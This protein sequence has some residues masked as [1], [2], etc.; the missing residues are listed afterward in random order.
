MPST[1]TPFRVA[2]VPGVTPGKWTKAWS[3][4]SS[5]PIEVT[6]IEVDD[7]RHV[8]LAGDADVAF[9][10]LPIDRDG[11]SVIRLY[12]EA[13]MVV[14]PRDH[15]V[16]LYDSVTLAELEGEI[17]RTEPLEDAIDLV[18]AGAGIML[19]PQSI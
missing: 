16:S 12:E 11:L 18:V 5:I 3:E 7:Q 19:L 13:P 4:R 9:V 2:I 8:L 17:V 14:V 6:P 15:P 1:A 10:R